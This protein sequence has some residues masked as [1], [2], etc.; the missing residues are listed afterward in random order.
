VEDYFR[1]VCGE[2]AVIGERLAVFEQALTELRDRFTDLSSLLEKTN[3]VETE[4][5]QAIADADKELCESVSFYETDHN[6]LLAGLNGF[7]A[8]Y[9]SGLPKENSAQHE[10]RHAFEPIAEAGRALIKQVDLLYKL[11]AC[12]VDA[13][14]DIPP[15]AMESLK[16]KNGTNGTLNPRLLRRMLKQLDEKRKA[17]VEQLKATTYFHRQIIWLQDRFPNAE[18][19]AVPGLVKLLDRKEIEAADW[20][21][22]PGRYVGVAPPEVDEDFDFEQTL[23]DIHVELAD[24]NKEA[25]ELAAKIQEN[26]MELG[27]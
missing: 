20:S 16:E 14:V 7:H 1:Q 24:L 17:A 6:K 11:V 5:K 9:A 15:T 23:R 10:T 27:V 8:R 22:T 19:Q 18:F 4:K 12:V 2:G 21:L 26:F 25:A 3:V 13:A